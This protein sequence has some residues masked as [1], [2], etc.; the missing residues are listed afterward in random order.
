M[1]VFLKFYFLT[2]TSVR[3]TFEKMDGI[4]VILETRQ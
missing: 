3:T 2:F 1:R 4:L